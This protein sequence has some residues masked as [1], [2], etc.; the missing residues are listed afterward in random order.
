MTKI[1]LLDYAREIYPS[2]KYKILKIADKFE[3][4]TFSTTILLLPVAHP[5]LNPIEMVWA[6]VKRSVASRYM[7]FQ[8]NAVEKL[9][10]EQ[11]N[12]VTDLQFKKYD[13]HA[14]QEE[15]K[16]PKWTKTS[17]IRYKVDSYLTKNLL[18]KWSPNSQH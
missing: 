1:Q 5:E 3:T 9:T 11:I 15:Y 18:D 7:H 12:L 17:T 2:P 10:R 16:Y 13:K 4:G 8:L 14:K 6:C